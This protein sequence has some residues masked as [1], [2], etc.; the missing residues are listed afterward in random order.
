MAKIVSDE[1][2]IA[3][4]WPLPRFGIH[5]VRYGIPLM[6]ASYLSLVL[7]LGLYLPAVHD[8]RFLY[9]LAFPVMACILTTWGASYYDGTTILA[10]RDHITLRR[11]WRQPTVVPIS[12]VARIVRLTVDEPSKN[13]TT[14]RPA[15]FFFNSDSR[16]ILSLFSARFDDRDLAQLWTTIGIQPEGS[17]HEHV[18]TMKLGDRFPGAF[19]KP[20]A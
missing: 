16:C 10:N 20:A 9:D 5:R 11:W 18:K 1:I 4:H 3:A 6:A 7:T 15:L 13:G 17:L 2:E 12:E 8:P 19:D 14:P